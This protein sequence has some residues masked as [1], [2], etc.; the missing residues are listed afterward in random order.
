MDYSSH[1]ISNG[2][3]E[4]SSQISFNNQFFHNPQQ[5]QQQQ[6]VE[7]NSNHHQISFGLLHHSTSSSSATANPENFIMKENGGAYDMGELDQALF[8]YLDGQEPSS[9]Q[10]Q[11][12]M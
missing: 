9:I 5:Q 12:R 4:S 1:K 10:D 6:Q 2:P 3:F 7:N 8:L 11:R